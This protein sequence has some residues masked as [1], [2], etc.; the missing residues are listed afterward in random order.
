[1][2]LQ[3]AGFP[4]Q[5]AAPHECEH[6]VVTRIPYPSCRTVGAEP[7]ESSQSH[8]WSASLK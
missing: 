1:M 7:Y 4:C 5:E 2:R 8:A 3:A 6:A